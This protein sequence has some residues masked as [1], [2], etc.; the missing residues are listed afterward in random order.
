MCQCQPPFFPTSSAS[1]PTWRSR[2][3]FISMSPASGGLELK[4]ASAAEMTLEVVLANFPKS[5]NRWLISVFCSSD[6]PWGGHDINQP[7]GVPPPIPPNEKDF[8]RNMLKTKNIID[9]HMCRIP[10]SAPVPPTGVSMKPPTMGRPP[11]ELGVGK[12]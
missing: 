12:G 4:Q 10:C 7:R 3:R 9:D 1:A 2:V 11:I 5:C 8:D 6:A